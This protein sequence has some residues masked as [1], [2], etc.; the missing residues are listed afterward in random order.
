LFAGN[1][2]Y[3]LPACIM[4]AAIA[5]IF[6]VHLKGAPRR[7]RID[8]NIIRRFAIAAVLFILL[9]AVVFLPNV[10]HFNL[11][12]DHPNERPDA[13]YEPPAVALSQVLT[14]ETNIPSQLNSHHYVLMVVPVW[15]AA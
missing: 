2:Y 10:A 1:I 4:A 11:L 12:G 8:V 13:H 9:A 7:L 3:I 6:C 14:F 5:L 15:F